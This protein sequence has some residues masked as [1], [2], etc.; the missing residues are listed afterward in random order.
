[1][2]EK[3]QE[4]VNDIFRKI[5]GLNEI[6][7]ESKADDEK[8]KKHVITKI[9]PTRH[10][11][12]IEDITDRKDFITLAKEAIGLTKYTVKFKKLD[13]RAVIPKYSHD[14]DV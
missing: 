3:K 2:V 13:E 12:E 7:K 1:M 9:V 6:S 11:N 5:Y 4:T 8:L 10:G 14:G